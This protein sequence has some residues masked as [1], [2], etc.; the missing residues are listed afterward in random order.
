MTESSDIYKSE[1]RHKRK[2]HDENETFSSR[3]YIRYWRDCIEVNRTGS[4]KH[5]V[6]S[7]RISS[8][9][10]TL[11]SNVKVKLEKYL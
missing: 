3:R 4:R 7:M 11:P 2:S 10:P 1:S 8:E 5:S 6:R 9:K